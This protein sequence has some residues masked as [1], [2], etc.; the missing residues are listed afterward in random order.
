[1]SLGRSTRHS[2]IDAVNWERRHVGGP[3]KA[4]SVAG[5]RVDSYVAGSIS[6]SD[7]HRCD[8]ATCSCAHHAAAGAQQPDSRWI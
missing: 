1:M 4:H 3:W 5:Q 7:L 2:R 6:T 8:R